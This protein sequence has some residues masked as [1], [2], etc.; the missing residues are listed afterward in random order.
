[1]KIT[2]KDIF[3]VS[4]TMINLATFS[5]TLTISNLNQKIRFISNNLN[6]N[7]VIL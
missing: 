2:T 1:M 5:F 4:M 7:Q 3:V 6:P